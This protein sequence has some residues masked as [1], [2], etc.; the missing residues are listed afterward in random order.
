MLNTDTWLEGRYP[1]I[2]LLTT[3]YI[4][5]STTT[6]VERVLQVYYNKSCEFK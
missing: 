1:I 5:G 3:V 6:Y 4:F 2:L